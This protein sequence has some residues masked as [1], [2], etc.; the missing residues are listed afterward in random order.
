MADIQNVGRFTISPAETQP[1]DALDKTKQLDV[2]QDREVKTDD[3]PPSRSS[4]QNWISRLFKGG[5]PD[6]K[7]R[8]VTAD[9]ARAKLAEIKSN[10]GDQITSANQA[11]SEGIENEHSQPVRTFQQQANAIDKAIDEHERHSD[12]PFSKAEKKDLVSKFKQLHRAIGDAAPSSIFAKRKVEV[13]QTQITDRQASSDTEN[14][15]TP[16]FAR[17]KEAYQAFQNLFK[18]TSSGDHNAQTGQGQTQRME[19]PVSRKGIMTPLEYAFSPSPGAEKQAPVIRQELKLAEGER[20]MAL[21][22]YDMIKD[23]VPNRLEYLR[24]EAEENGAL[25]SYSDTERSAHGALER[26][27]RV[28]AAIVSK[29]GEEL[30]RSE[31]REFNN[32]VDMIGAVLG[33]RLNHYHC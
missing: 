9:Q 24:A 2:L 25:S 15:S 30:S 22:Y 11:H 5:I 8:T 28:C 17:L 13:S 12:K 23:L 4:K 33:E 18:H 3:S 10:Y 16:R 31:R 1:S 27:D 14:K 32:E 26:L 20:L 7:P 6:L 29:E 21:S 19:G